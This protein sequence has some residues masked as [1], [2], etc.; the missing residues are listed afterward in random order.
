MNT[1]TRNHRMTDDTKQHMQAIVQDRY[2]S[3]EVLQLRSIERPEVADDEVLIEVHA[4]GLDRGVWHLM[5]GL[6]YL[7]R[8]G[9]GLTKPK[10][11]VP[12]MDVAGRVVA[13][14]ER[15]TRFAVDDEVFGIADGSFAEY[16]TAREAKLVQKPVAVTYEQAAVAAISGITALQA[17]TD[18]G[19]LER[20]QRVLVIG[21]SGGVGSYAVQLAKAMGAT[22]SGV[23]SG[24]KAESVRS[25]GV[26]HV[27]DYAADDYLD[28]SIRYDLIIDTGGL[29]PVRKLR[30]ALT[31]TGTLVIVGGEGGDRW[32]GG[33]GRQIRATLMSSFVRQR[34]TMFI[35][36]EH[37]SFIDR[38]AGFMERGEVVPVIGRCYDLAEVPSA[39]ADLEAGRAT[40]KSV[41]NVRKG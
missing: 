11:P 13:I 2:G 7:V 34:L 3:A 27:F 5:T 20:G 6:P 32:T 22:V 1:S 24:A 38:L 19:Q 35:S 15:V 14:G 28:G 40:G 9:F 10:N 29:N 16:A 39:I 33:I 23:A 18:V 26:D 30:N 36:R 8:L 4:A 37:H 31:L 21:A 25:L 41:V 12:G 17:L